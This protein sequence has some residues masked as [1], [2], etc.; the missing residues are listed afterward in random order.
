[1][2]AIFNLEKTSISAYPTEAISPFDR[3]PFKGIFP[4]SLDPTFA[5]ASNTLNDGTF[6]LGT[7]TAVGGA[8]EVLVTISITSTGSATNFFKISCSQLP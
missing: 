3:V 2:T 8:Y 4:Y 5:C 1:M 7:P 6:T